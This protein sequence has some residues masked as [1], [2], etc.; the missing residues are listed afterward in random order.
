[1]DEKKLTVEEIITGLD[2][3]SYYHD[4]ES[5]HGFLRGAIGL[6][7]DLQSE[8][9]R[10]NDMKFTQEHCDLYSENEFLRAELHRELSEH[11]EFAKK[12][13][14]EIER[15]KNAYREGLEQ[16]KFD[17]QVKV[18]ELQKQVDELKKENANVIS[19]NDALYREKQRLL[20]HLDEEWV[21]LKAV[22]AGQNSSKAMK[23]LVESVGC[24]QKDTA[25]EIL[26]GM[27]G[28]IHKLTGCGVPYHFKAFVKEWADRY[29]VEVE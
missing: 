11:E 5:V 20:K 24:V 21:S 1:M 23:I 8:N 10:L 19:M 28:D 13:K 15:L 6:I 3:L 12:A 14:A 9:E 22:K 29:G 4:E 2:N 16:G 17:N 7:Q 27:L 18:A 26:Q 25:K